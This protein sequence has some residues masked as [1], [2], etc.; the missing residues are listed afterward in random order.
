MSEEYSDNEINGSEVE[1]DAQIDSAPAG[2]LSQA[3]TD[4]L[5]DGGDTQDTDARQSEADALTG[6]NQDPGQIVSQEEI[7]ELAEQIANG[8]TIARSENS[9][10]DSSSGK[11]CG[12]DVDLVTQE[13]LDALMSAYQSVNTSSSASY[14]KRQKEVR[15]YD[16]SRPDR[17]SK[18]QLRTINAIHADFASGLSS[19]LT[20][21]YQS[22]THVNLIALEQVSYAEYRAS[23]PSKTLI[24]EVSV[25]SLNSDLIF[26]V[27]PNVVGVWV[28]CL[29]G[30]SPHIVAEPSELTP[31]DLA[32]AKKVLSNCLQVYSDIWS[33]MV[34]IEPE[35]RRVVS[36]EHYDDILLPSDTVLV[37]SIE[38]HVAQ[39]FGMMTLCIPASAVEA[40][41]PILSAA[42]RGRG[43]NRRVDKSIAENL[44]YRIEPVNLPCRV[45]LGKTLI[46]FSDVMNLQVGDVIRTSKR[47]DS[48]I[49]LWI[50]S[51]HMF[52]G[53]PGIKGKNLALMIASKAESSAEDVSTEVQTQAATVEVDELS[54]EAAA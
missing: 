41:L 19:A 48:D 2:P 30:G 28:D 49:E 27:N 40:V 35:L 38:I 7:N 43:A 52:N 47:A 32:V 22:Q 54:M 3:D 12:S 26:E 16:F 39:S 25:E 11:G 29:C 20:G 1:Q 8:A 44:K 31:I 42:Q 5:L 34:N 9:S 13:E 36:S 33:D 15:L 21:L 18:D 53:R 50:S 24:A 37:C 10:D 17:F 45:V 46:S 6:S 4:A 23:I 14:D 51:R